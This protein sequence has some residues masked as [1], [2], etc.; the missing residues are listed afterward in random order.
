MLDQNRNI[1]AIQHVLYSIFFCPAPT[2]S[3]FSLLCVIS[4][5]LQF[6]LHLLDSVLNFTEVKRELASQDLPG[7]ALLP[8]PGDSS[9]PA[10]EESCSLVQSW[11]RPR[12]RFSQKINLLHLQQFP[13]KQIPK[14]IVITAKALTPFQGNS[15]LLSVGADRGALPGNVLFANV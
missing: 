8:Q 6:I 9:G 13:K 11:R 5:T 12:S 14:Y 3:L 2:L 7:S 15:E 4:L 10:V 1:C